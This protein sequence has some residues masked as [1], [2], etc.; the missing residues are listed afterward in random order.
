V[1]ALRF[2][3]SVALAV[4]LLAGVF[5]AGVLVGGHP[6]ATGITQM[7]ESIRGFLLGS[8]G[9][10]LTGQVLDVL[11]DEYYEDFDAGAL[12]SAGVEG[13]IEELGD[14]FTVYLTREDLEQ[15]R[16]RNNGTYFG[17]GLQVAQ[18][19]DRIEVTRVFEGGPAAEAGVEEG[20]FLVSVDGTPVSGRDVD[21]AVVDIRGPEGTE[22]TVGF[23]RP[24]EGRRE[25]ELE[26]AEIQVPV[27]ESE[28]RMVGGEDVGYVRLSQFTRGSAEAMRDAVAGLEEDG[29]DALVFDLR[30][31]PGGLVEEAIGVAGAFLPEG[32]DVVTTEGRES[33]RRTLTTDTE[34]VSVD[35]PLVVL[36]DRGSASASEIVAGA[37]RDQD[38]AE[39]VGT[40]TFGKA[41]VQS[42][43]P[44]R[45]GGALK[46]TT[47]RYLTPDGL[48]INER[49]LE[50]DV[51]VVDDPETGR[52]EALQEALSLASVDTSPAQASP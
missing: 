45:D 42:T 33:P 48:D 22:V 9:Q 7:P 46:L 37:L 17:V 52:D 43:V 2:A 4:V 15:L 14:P 10:D 35:T 49:G 30:G 12:E 29:V 36:V 24:G 25:V 5:L 6:R 16:Q 34:P 20:D 50:P 28:V 21:T 1:S 19:E 41:L 31:D 27:V 23:V 38:R 26:R 8:S 44:L 13:L 11:E 3:L 47:A 40:R 18:N 51:R 32:A 39:L